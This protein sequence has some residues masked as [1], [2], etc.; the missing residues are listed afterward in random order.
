[1]DLLH[2][3]DEVDFYQLV[4]L[5]HD[6]ELVFDELGDL[7]FLLHLETASTSRSREHHRWKTGNYLAEPDTHHLGVGLGVTQQLPLQLLPHWGQSE[8]RQQLSA[9]Q[10]TSPRLQW[11]EN[12]HDS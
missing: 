5:G 11:F 7:V 9:V 4:N 12:R 6:V 8:F 3:G 1:M 2:Q 10:W